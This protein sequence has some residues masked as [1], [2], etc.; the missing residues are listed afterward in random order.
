M[1][2]YSKPVLC[3][4]L[5]GT[6]RFNFYDREGF[7]DGPEEVA[8]YEEVR[9][10][11]QDARTNRMAVYGISNQGGVAYGYKSVR[12]CQMIDT[13]TVELLGASLIDGIVTAYPMQGGKQY[14][15]SQRSLL[16]KP[17]YGMLGVVEHMMFEKGQVTDWNN[18]LIVGDRDEDAQLASFAEVPFMWAEDWRQQLNENQ[19]RT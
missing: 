3:L 13:T 12:D 15:F 9:E 2:Y 1:E 14:P 19:E 11:I 8:I 10:L 16:R 6:I 17:M 7:I 4:D 18:S 5:D